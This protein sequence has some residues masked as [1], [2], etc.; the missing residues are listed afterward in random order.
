MNV[1]IDR[2]VQ[3]VTGQES[4]INIDALIKLAGGSNSEYGKFLRGPRAQHIVRCVNQKLQE[5]NQALASEG[6]HS[7]QYQLVTVGE[8]HRRKSVFS[9][10]HADNS[11]RNAYDEMMLIVV[12]ERAAETLRENAIAWI[13]LFE[14]PNIVSERAILKEFARELAHKTQ[15]H[16]TALRLVSIPA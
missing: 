1:D 4:V 13:E 6:I 15:K 5:N 14:E 12:D 3:R 2:V 11:Y 16:K 10:E 9:L 8:F 7:E